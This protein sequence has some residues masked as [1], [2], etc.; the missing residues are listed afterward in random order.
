M[1]IKPIAVWAVYTTENEYGN[2]GELLTVMTSR[3]AAEKES[4]GKGWYGG[5][6]AVE[7]RKVIKV[8]NDKHFLLDEKVDYPI[9]LDK[10]V[11]DRELKLRKQALKKLSKDEREVLGLIDDK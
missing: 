8:G 6:G 9:P 10:K 11:N 5:Q 7:E 3:V 1:K 4:Q 2:L